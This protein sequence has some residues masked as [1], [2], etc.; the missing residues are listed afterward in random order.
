MKAR[1]K[2]MDSKDVLF[3]NA[4][5]LSSAYTRATLAP[6]PSLYCVLIL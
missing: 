4:F 3:E 6:R 5:F 1:F 2:S